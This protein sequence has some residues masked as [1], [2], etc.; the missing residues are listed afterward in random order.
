LQFLL[1]NAGVAA[2]GLVVVAIVTIAAA[3]ITITKSLVLVFCIANFLN[4]RQGI[5]GS[6]INFLSQK[7]SLVVISSS[8]AFMLS[9]NLLNTVTSFVFES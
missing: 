6:Q 1:A 3:V 8:S 5:K 7:T 9:S 4:I 2:L